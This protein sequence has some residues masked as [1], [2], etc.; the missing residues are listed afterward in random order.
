VGVYLDDDDVDWGEL[1]ELL[2][3]AY[4]RTA[5]KRLAALLDGDA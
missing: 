2:R 3:D 5:P 1:A 4:R